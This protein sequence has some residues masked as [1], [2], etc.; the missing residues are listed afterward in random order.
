VAKIENERYKERKRK[1]ERERQGRREITQQTRL[2]VY[3]REFHKAGGELS[4]GMSHRSH[5]QSA[6][7]SCNFLLSVSLPLW[8]EG[9]GV[10]R[11]FC[12]FRRESMQDNDF[13]MHNLRQ[14]W[15]NFND[16]K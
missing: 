6:T 1:I 2:G 14:V 16:K 11:N 3:V 4:S 9:Q 7:E 13:N 8:P 10:F 15:E 5:R 12:E